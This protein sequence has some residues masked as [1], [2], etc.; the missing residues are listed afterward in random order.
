MNQ[1]FSRT[2]FWILT[3]VIILIAISAPILIATYKATSSEEPLAVLIAVIVTLILALLILGLFL[4]ALPGWNYLEIDEQGFKIKMGRVNVMHKWT[5][6]SRFFRVEHGSS[7]FFK[8]KYLVGC[9]LANAGKGERMTKTI[10]GAHVVLV[11]TYGVNPPDLIDV[12][13][14]YRDRVL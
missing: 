5:E 8:K 13:N 1:R 2:N 10:S 12:M 14:E 6:C 3:W 9:D 11:D 7:I 4:I